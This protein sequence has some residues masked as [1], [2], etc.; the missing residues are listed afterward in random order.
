MQAQLTVVVGLHRTGQSSMN[1]ETSLLTPATTMTQDTECSMDI[2]PID[3][4]STDLEAGLS[5]TEAQHTERL[6]S[7]DNH[8][9]GGDFA[10]GL[11]ETALHKL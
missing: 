7:T 6:I 3:S 1:S 11:T 9:Q 4:P 5:A 2:S 10:E 8:I